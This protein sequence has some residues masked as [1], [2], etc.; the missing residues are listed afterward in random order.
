VG[1]PPKDVSVRRGYDRWAASYDSDDNP[2]TALEAPVVRR[3]LGRV[4]GKR[5]LDVGCGTGRHSVWLAQRGA[6]VVGVDFS[7]GM[8][9]KACERAGRAGVAAEF[10]VHDASRPLPLAAR[11]FDVVL[12]CLVLE[13]VKDL[14]GFFRQLARVCRR[15]GEVVVT[16]MHPAMFL[17]GKSANFKDASGAKVRPKSQHGQTLSDYVMAAVRAG[18]R[19]DELLERD[20]AKGW[21]ALV[22]MRLS[23]R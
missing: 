22:V 15:D 5:V 14:D 18:L 21:P 1:R 17:L 13:H 7:K 10:F 4:R 8:L 9:A 11:S 12:S 3:L 6:D 23:P 16:A 20:D 2:L 19:I